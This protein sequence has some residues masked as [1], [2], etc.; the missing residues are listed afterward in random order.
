M[1]KTSLH[2]FK[3]YRKDGIIAIKLDEGNALIDVR[4]TSGGDEAILVTRKG[5]SLRFNEEQARS[6]GRATAGVQGI[7]PV[8]DD[9]VVGLALVDEDGTLLVASENGI[10]KRSPF[11]DYRSQ[12]RG[13]KGIITMKCTEKTGD[14]V[15]ASMVYPEDELMLMTSSG[16]SIRI[17]CADVREAGRN[18]QG[19]K[20]VGLKGGEKLQDIARV[21]P[22][23]ES[24]DEE[25]DSEEASEQVEE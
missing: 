23:E 10:G 15:G 24:E 25:V 20:L 17:R 16:Q 8:A 1:K 13:G 12:T 7:K 14:V 22:D 9:Y 18:T 6:M 2:D 11:A 5:L 3:N 19:V 4:L 21:V